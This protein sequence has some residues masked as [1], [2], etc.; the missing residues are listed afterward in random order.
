MGTAT[1]IFMRSRQ[2]ASHIENSW[3]SA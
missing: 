1:I 3:P 2:N